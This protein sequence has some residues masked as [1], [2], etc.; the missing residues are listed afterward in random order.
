[1]TECLLRKHKALSS[2]PS[3]TNKKDPCKRR[4]KSDA[5]KVLMEIIAEDIQNFFKAQIYRIKRVN[6][7]QMVIFL[8]KICQDKS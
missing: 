4:K 6:E 3:T 8:K 2:I 5:E 7:T 1:V